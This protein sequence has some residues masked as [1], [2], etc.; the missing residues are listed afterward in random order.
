MTFH[1]KVAEVLE[2]SPE[3]LEIPLQN[4]D[5]WLSKNADAPHRLNEWQRI[6]QEAQTSPQ[7]FQKMLQ[8]LRSPSEA[9]LHLKSYT[10]FHGILTRE[11]RRSTIESCAFR[12]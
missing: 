2:I 11:E 9:A 12:H 10:P 3:R 8:L 4:I 1:E 6:I 7:S 5:R